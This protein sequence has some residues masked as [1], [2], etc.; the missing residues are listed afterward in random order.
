MG[1]FNGDGKLDLAV[2]SGIS[3]VAVLMGNGNGTFGP[4]RYTPRERPPIRGRA[5]DFNGDGKLDLAVADSDAR[6]QLR[7]HPAGQRR[8]HIRTAAGVLSV[9]GSSVYPTL[10]A[11][12]FTRKR[13]ARPGRIPPIDGEVTVLLQNPDGTFE[14]PDQNQTMVAV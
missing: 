8:R 5:G 12:D 14:S 9:Q 4:R 6:R 10:V 7:L 13:P 3:D 2:N 11:A 1:D